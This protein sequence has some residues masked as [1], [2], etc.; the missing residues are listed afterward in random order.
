MILCGL[1]EIF[2]NIWR[3]NAD[4]LSSAAVMATVAEQPCACDEVGR[5]VL[6]TKK[7]HLTKEFTRIEIANHHF[8]LWVFDIVDY[9]RD[10]T[11]QDE[12]EVLTGFALTEYAA[13]DFIESRSQCSRNASALGIRLLTR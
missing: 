1:Y 9:H 12:V 10:R 2:E 6:L 8:L 3:A 5:T 11:I 4:F 7:S 13:L